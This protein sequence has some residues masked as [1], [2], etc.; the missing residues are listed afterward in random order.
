M[1]RIGDGVAR[2]WRQALEKKFAQEK[3]KEE[4]SKPPGRKCKPPSA[5]TLRQY[6]YQLRWISQRMDGFE[7]GVK[8]PP[9]EEVLEYMENAK[10]NKHRRRNVYVAMKMWHTGCSECSCCE[11]YSTHLNRCCD[12]ISAGLEKQKKTKRMEKNWIEFRELKKFAGK[13]RDEVLKYPK[14]EVWTKEQYVKATLCFLMLFHLKY[15]VRRDLYRVRVDTTEGNHLDREKKSIV[16][17]EYKTSKT[18]GRK[19][20]IL[21]RPMWTIASRLM[22][23]QSMRNMEV[24]HLILNSYFEPMKPNG[25]SQWFQRELARYCES[26]KGKKCGVTMM[27]HIVITHLNRNEKSIQE[28]KDLADKCMHSV[29]MHDQYRKIKEEPSSASS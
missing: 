20:F 24:T 13:L 16:L 1:P 19:E 28:K 2:I 23:Q 10:I 9:P 15:P 25:F 21:S 3:V 14:K 8:V 22:Q 27:R 6:A 7:T 26:A 5:Q 11:K 17:T 29:K 18:Y 4:I 12:E